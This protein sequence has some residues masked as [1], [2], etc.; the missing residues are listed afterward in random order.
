MYWANAYLWGCALYWY[1]CGVGIGEHKNLSMMIFFNL[2][3]FNF[4]LITV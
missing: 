4:P 2:G 3:G 1:K